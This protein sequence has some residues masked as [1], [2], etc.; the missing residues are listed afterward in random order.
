[1]N[2]TFT[3]PAGALIPAVKYVARWLDTKPSIPILGGIVFEAAAG[4]LTIAG[5]SELATARAVLDV[6]G[7]ADGR[8]I[9]AG[10]LVDAIAATLTDKPILFEQVGSVVRMKAGRYAVDLPA[11]SENDYPDLARLAP[12]AGRVEGAT[13]VA[14][15]QR[16]GIAAS[17]NHESQI[18]LT[19]INV[20]F[21]SDPDIGA[22]GD[23]LAYTLTL[24][25]T[26][27]LRVNRQRIEWEPDSEN[28]P[29]GESF[30]IPA[31]VMADAAEAFSSIEPVEIGWQE[32]AVS[33]STSTRS[34]VTQTLG[35]PNGYLDLAVLYRELDKRPNT[36]TL[37]VKDLM[38][39]LKRA[40]HLADSEYKHVHL[41]LSPG[42]LT[43][44]SATDGKG[45]GGE[46]IDVEYDGPNHTIATRS[47]ILH[48]L[49]SSV[50]GDTVVLH[51]TPGAYLSVF[52]TSPAEPDWMHLF[53]P[54][55]HT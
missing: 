54:I 29:I 48:G 40:D 49:L 47:G 51:L 43:L 4:V 31:S 41:D 27:K 9:V 53:M 2:G 14:A 30:V 50:P 26:D 1:M 5:Q 46:E 15:A 37:R 12:I 36:V 21:D 38:A 34:L 6:Q 39:P 19:G 44:R 45:G 8:F 20:R 11:M 35:G 10:R 18:V 42:L 16:C 24:E 25:A 23:P 13:F 22:D 33:L 28:A 55:R 52:A 7:D 17:R 3:A 32:G